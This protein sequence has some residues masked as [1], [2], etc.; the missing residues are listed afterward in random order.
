MIQLYEKGAYVFGG[1]HV[2]AET[3]IASE[4]RKYAAELPEKDTVKKNT[5]GYGRNASPFAD[6]QRGKYGITCSRRLSYMGTDRFQVGES[7]S[8]DRW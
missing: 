4:Y 8:R 2:V 5:L 3:Q 1:N 7:P 6:I